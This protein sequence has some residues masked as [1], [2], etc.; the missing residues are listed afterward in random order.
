MNGSLT[1]LGRFFSDINPWARRSLSEFVYHNSNEPLSWFYQKYYASGSNCRYQTFHLALNLLFQR[2]EKPLIVETGCQRL[3]DDIGAGMSTSIFGEYVH[4]YGGRLVTVDFSEQNLNICRES[5]A[6]FSDKIQY[7]FS[8][9]LVFLKQLTETPGLIY[10]DS[11]DYDINGSDEDRRLSQEHCLK[12]WLIVEPLLKDD[13]IVLLDDNDLPGGGK[14]KKVK[15]DLS[16]KGW[17]CL[18]DWQQSLWV[19]KI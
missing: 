6:S 12:E 14:P 18:L 16:S 4:R 9:S 19:K 13:T 15:A 10:L 17:T 1:K 7:V 5:T 2:H 11:Y 3:K 8:D